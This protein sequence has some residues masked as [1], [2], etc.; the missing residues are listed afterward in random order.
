MAKKSLP[1]TFA[2][3]F[4]ALALLGVFFLWRISKVLKND[5]AKATSYKQNKATPSGKDADDP[6]RN[7]ANASSYKQN[8]ATP[9]GKNADD[10]GRERSPMIT[11][12]TTGKIIST[13]ST[14]CQHCTKKGKTESIKSAGAFPDKTPQKKIM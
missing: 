3:S 6:V 12:N 10:P 14:K 4:T 1:W 5:D 7:D 11:T 8:K 2:F 9:S 13:K